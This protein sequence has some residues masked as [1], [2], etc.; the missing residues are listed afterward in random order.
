[1]STKQLLSAIDA[2][3][4]QELARLLDGRDSVDGVCDEA[5]APVKRGDSA[6]ARTD[7][8]LARAAR[9]GLPSAARLLLEAGAAVDLGKTGSGVTALFIAVYYG[10]AEVVSLLILAGAAVN[11]TLPTGATPLHYAVHEARSE[12]VN[13]LLLA[14]AD[15]NQATADGATPL[16]AAA[17]QGHADVVKSL[18]EAGAT[19]DRAMADGSTPLAAATDQGHLECAQLLSSYGASRAFTLSPHRRN[20]AH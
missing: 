6:T 13:L 1:M 9:R 4:V 8:P 20:R 17:F 3:A 18:L 14:G 19:V 10:H 16:F 12:V 11:Q 2:G 7:T 15:V 5:S